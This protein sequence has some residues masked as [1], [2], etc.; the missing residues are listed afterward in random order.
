MFYKKGRITYG[1]TKALLSLESQEGSLEQWFLMVAQL[2]LGNVG[3][4]S[5]FLRNRKA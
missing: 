1:K 4:N 5:D 3:I 2:N